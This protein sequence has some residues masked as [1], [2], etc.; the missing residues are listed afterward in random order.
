[1]SHGRYVVRLPFKSDPPISLGECRV[2]ALASFQRMEQCLQREPNKTSEYCDFLAEYE[3]LGHMVKIPT[4]EIS[5]TPRYYIPH[6]AVLRDSSATTRLCVYFNASCQTTNSTSLNDY[7]LIGPKFQ[8][9]SATVN[10]QWRQYHYVYTANITKMYRQ[11]L[12]D[13]R[14]TD[15]YRI[16]WRSSSSEPIHDYRLLIVTYGTAAAPYLAL[17]VLEQLA[18]DDGAQFPLAVPVLRHQ[19]YVD[20]CVFG[21]DDKILARQTRDQLIALLKK[22]GFCLRKGKQFPRPAIRHR[23]L[24]LWVSKSQNPTGGRVHQGAWNYLATRSRCF[25]IPS[26]HSAISRKDETSHPIDHY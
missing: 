20:D 1:M 8:K 3:Q 12:V 16:L 5:V 10:M 15:Y 24:R 22:G 25:P 17:R 6:N 21:T 23:S 13:A 2:T 26:I 9:D 11:I 19:I 7:I 14:D 18:D 4:N